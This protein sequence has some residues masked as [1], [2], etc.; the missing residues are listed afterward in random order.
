MA[1][2]IRCANCGQ[3][4]AEDPSG[5]CPACQAPTT[6]DQGATGAY[7]PPADSASPCGDRVPFTTA[8]VP[9]R[10]GDY[11]ILGEIARGG[12][13]VVYRAR[14]T[15][16]NR[17][18]AL[19]M[20]RFAALADDAEVKRFRA[21]AEAAAGLDHPHI[22]P[23]YEVGEH[24]GQHFFSMKLLAGSLAGLVADLSRDPRRTAQIVALVAR[25]VHHAHQRRILHRDLKPANVLLDDQGEPHV[26]DF[27][28]AKAIESDSGL[29]RSG[30]VLGT[31]GYM[32][33]EQAAG[34][35]RSLTTACDVYG[36]GA[37]LYE[38]LTGRPPFKGSTAETLRLVL[39][40]E[41]VPP[42]SLNPAADRDL[43]TIAL[44]CL[45]KEPER[46]YDSAEAVA[47]DLERRLRGAAI[48]ARRVGRAERLLLWARRRPALAVA[49][50]LAV[51][52]VVLGALGGSA[53]WLWQRAEVARGQAD[54]A[55]E[56]AEQARRGEQAANERLE[57][58]LYQRRVWLAHADW[59]ENKITSMEQELLACPA[60]L[61]RWEWHY[62]D[63]LCH[64]ELRGYRFQ[65][66][67][68]PLVLSPDGER[69]VVSSFDGNVQIWDV[70]TGKELVALPKHTAGPPCCLCFSPDGSRLATDFGV[71]VKV[72]EV[73]TGQLLL[74]LPH[75]YSVDAV[76]FSRDNQTV[77]TAGRAMPVRLWDAGKG[78][79]ARV[80]TDTPKLGLRV[81]CLSFSP[82]GQLLA[83]GQLGRP[84][85]VRD[86][87]TGKEL[88]ALPTNGDALLSLCFSPDGRRLATTWQKGTVR[89]MD[90]VTGREEPA[91]PDNPFMAEAVCFSP[92]SRFLA[93]G[94]TDRIVRI[95]DGRTGQTIRT[96]KGHTSPVSGL[97]FSA[98]GK[99]LVS[100][101]ADGVVKVWDPSAD[102]DARILRT[103]AGSGELR[104]SL[105]GRRL[106]VVQDGTV[107]L[108]DVRTGAALPPLGK[109]DG[110]VVG[111]GFT[112]A[113]LRVVRS[114]PSGGGTVQDV[115]TDQ[116]PRRLAGDVDPIGPC[117]FSADGRLLAQI[118]L[119]E[120]RLW[121]AD[122]GQ[123]LLTLRGPRTGISGVDFS[124]DGRFLAAGCVLDQNVHV[125]DVRTGEER[126][127][128][129][130]PHS[131]VHGLAF[132]PDGHRLAA[133]G[134]DGAVRTWD[135]QTGKEV[136]VRAGNVD[137]FLA[138]MAGAVCWS[139][140]GQR[141]VGLWAR[142]TVQLWD[143]PTGEEVL[144]L[145]GDGSLAGGSLRICF[146]PDGRLLAGCHS[147][148]V[149]L[150]QTR[151]PQE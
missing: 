107:H 20:I 147:G 81:R 131:Q 114:S 52:V 80:L 5:H 24:Q 30:A 72:W 44:K 40:Q 136:D 18:V 97:A 120:V 149:R 111:M 1:E 110:P 14:Q 65:T 11:E 143:V 96:L 16:L 17:L 144:R 53:A 129:T 50:V 61:R 105:D 23:I 32:A 121:D 137:E 91:P 37:I 150:W 31:P 103:G 46:R 63:R 51:L 115:E 54:Q 89:L 117:S 21:E 142:G 132:H 70:A 126:L 101:A 135:L 41:P 99:R 12:M 42:R 59:R 68:N 64:F 106:A 27:G 77:A 109:Q 78:K 39:T 108:W 49:V 112:T 36:V 3:L 87:R 113:G 74:T 92:D 133:I 56:Q 6:L 145:A 146:S 128:P 134:A 95:R 47:E 33:P 100:A 62:L 8:P 119:K 124:P 29:T 86:V 13:G 138:H 93:T 4:T 139:P 85:Q 43:E 38:C 60:R 118:L 26:T 19:K 34:Q 84:I 58:V 98:D 73:R 28:L 83:V 140:D 125:W 79:D 82:D 88:S 130:A 25:A 22:V 94:A 57:Q 35:T 148:T 102:Q 76:C 116:P 15:S 7:T 123:F 127:V 2:S 141:L 104:F 122:T 48:L 151:T 67:G 66:D 90:P 45:R 75:E 10:F 9:Q 71:A 55:R 69:L